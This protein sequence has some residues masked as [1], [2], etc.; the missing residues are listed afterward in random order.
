MGP[1]W[2]TKLKENLLA[3]FN[4]IIPLHLF[5]AYREASPIY[6]K[7][8]S[9]WDK[10]FLSMGIPSDLSKNLKVR[11]SPLIY[12]LNSTHQVFNRNTANTSVI[13]LVVWQKQE[14]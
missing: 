11:P 7:N 3:I 8:D 10:V 5:R 9:V 13:F 6:A 14:W 2:T 12:C 4:L 1:T